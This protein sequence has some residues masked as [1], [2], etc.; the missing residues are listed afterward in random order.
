VT[1]KKFSTKFPVL[2]ALA[3]GLKHKI[4]CAPSPCCWTQTLC[5]L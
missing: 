3:A 2:Q 5:W 1:L 4:S